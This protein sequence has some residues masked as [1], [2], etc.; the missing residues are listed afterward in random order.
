[1]EKRTYILTNS[2]HKEN[3]VLAV[4]RIE[5]DSNKPLV[6]TIE[7]KTDW[8]SREQEKLF[9]KLV[10]LLADEM[11]CQLG[12]LK[13]AIKVCVIGYEQSINPL[14]GEVQE[15]LRSSA[16]Y[17]KKEYTALIDYTYQAAA[18]RGIILPVP[19]ELYKGYMR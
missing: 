18:E 9:H 7:H 16:K 5:P 15:H 6:V 2:T 10:S 1:M 8:K 17:T 3:A 14:T 19:D 4:M 12:D 13:Q 11:S